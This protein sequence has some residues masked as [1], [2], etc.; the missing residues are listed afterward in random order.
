MIVEILQAVFF[1]FVALM[2]VYMVRHYVFTLAVLRLAKTKNLQTWVPFKAKYEPSVTILIPARNEDQVIGRLLR[3]ITELTY[4][5]EKLQVIVVDDASNDR[6]GEIAEKYAK[7]SKVIEVLH[8]TRLEGGG[9]GK[10]AALNAALKRVKGEIVL[11]F[12]ADYIMQKDI[13]EKLVREFADPTV[14]AVQGRPVVRNE[15]KNII[16]RLVALERVGGYRI[17]Q[18]ARDKLGLIPQF[19]GTI[20][21]FRRSTI[22]STGGFDEKMITEDTDLTF[23]IR[24]LGYKIRYVGDAECYEEAVD[25]WRAYWKQ[26]HRWAKGHMQVCFKHSFSVLKSKRLSIKEKVDGL[27]LLNVYF[28]PVIALFSFFIS[29]SLMV[30][31]AWQ[32]VAALWFLVPISLYSC[33]GN[34][35]PFFEVGLGA[36]LDGRTRTQWLTPLLLMVFLY[37]IPICTNALLDVCIEKVSGRSIGGWSKTAHM[38]GDDL[39][40]ASLPFT[41]EGTK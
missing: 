11:C 10:A 41:L 13:V 25:T 39:Y 20:G 35:A 14:G 30:L 15:P 32:F 8:R 29:V 5:K 6:T 26:R 23:H 4:P 12:D 24:L 40:T 34:F 17:D 3:R 22:E 28:I 38:D 37:N 19:G 31:G 27:L 18:E 16:T 36:Y 33:V 9:S 1:F 7:Q 21:G 2:T